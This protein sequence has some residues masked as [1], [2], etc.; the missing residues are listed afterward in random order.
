MEERKEHGP[1]PVHQSGGN[2]WPVFVGDTSGAMGKLD[3]PQESLC[4]F[5]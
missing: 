2:A 3:H 5:K 4:Y 1:L